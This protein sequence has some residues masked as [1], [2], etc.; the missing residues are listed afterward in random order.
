[1]FNEACRDSA[2]APCSTAHATPLRNGFHFGWTR[3]AG[4]IA[5]AASPWPHRPGRIDL[6]ESTWPIGLPAS[7]WPHRPGLIGQQPAASSQLPA[8]SSRQPARPASPAKVKSVAQRSSVLGRSTAQVLRR[9]GTGLVASSLVRSAWRARPRCS[10]SIRQAKTKRL[11][12]KI[13]IS[14]ST[15]LHRTIW[16]DML[17]SSPHASNLVYIYIYI[18]IYIYM[19]IYIYCLLNT[20]QSPRD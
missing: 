20:S 2:R 17:A 4:R 12:K 11:A 7:P 1:M 19:Y 8:A 3:W 10:G 13:S 9:I 15:S 14:L 18:Y 16:N 6:A 5:L